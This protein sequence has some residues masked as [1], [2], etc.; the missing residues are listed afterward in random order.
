M[1]E[2]I[3]QRGQNINSEDTARFSGKDVLFQLDDKNTTDQ[4]L[5]LIYMYQLP[6]FVYH[7]VKVGMTKCKMGETFWHAIKSRIK[8]Q[9]HELAL[10]DDQFAKGYGDI[11]EVIYW[12]ICLDTNS[13][14]FKDYSVHAEIKAKYAGIQEKEQE[15]LA[16]AL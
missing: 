6:N 3:I 4:D 11:R 16:L 15:W 2:V 12:G 5:I 14:S 8:D 7:G 9:Q 10:T 13:E 1:S